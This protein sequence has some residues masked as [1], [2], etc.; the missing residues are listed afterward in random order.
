M[1]A[2]EIGA[3]GQEQ[4]YGE[5]FPAKRKWWVNG[6]LNG[7]LNDGLMVFNALYRDFVGFN[8]GLRGISCEYHG[9]TDI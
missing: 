8:C 7:G 2:Q 4:W 9:K 3:G 6:G 1:Q 5:Q